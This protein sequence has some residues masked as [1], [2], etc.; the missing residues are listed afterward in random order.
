MGRE[1]TQLHNDHELFEQKRDRI[2]AEY[3]VVGEAVKKI[4]QDP[5]GNWLYAGEPIQEAMDTLK[6]LDEKEDDDYLRGRN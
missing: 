6:K 1:Q 2:A 3:G 5:A 4:T